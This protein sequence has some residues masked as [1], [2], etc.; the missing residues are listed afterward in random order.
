L[1]R[2]T[3]VEDDAEIRSVLAT[4]LGESPGFRCVGTHGDCESAL[5]ALDAEQPDVVLMDI[6]LPGMSGIQGVAEVRRRLPGADVVMLTVHPDDA[7][8]YDALAAGAA[9]Y[10]LKGSRTEQILE[11]IRDVRRGGAP[12]SPVIARRVVESFRRAKESP[13]SPRE[14][15]VLGLLC[16]GRSYG[17]AARA[18]F[19]S[20]ETIHF[21]IKN[22]YRKLEVHSKSAAVARAIRDRLV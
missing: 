12:M 13:L 20:E 10:L 14:T 16:Q 2:V 4:L 7:Y 1:I 22:I 15:E 11:A 8:V 6:V 5:A 19:I 21:H 18:L 3:I 17:D 9:G